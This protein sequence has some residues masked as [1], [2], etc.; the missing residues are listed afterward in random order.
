LNLCSAIEDHWR[1]TAIKIALLALLRQILGGAG[2]P[3]QFFC[4]SWVV[5]FWRGRPWLT[6]RWIGRRAW[7]L[8]QAVSGSV[9]PQ[10]AATDVS[11]LRVGSDRSRRSQER[12][13]DGETACAR[14]LRSIV[15]LHRCRG[16]G[17]PRLETELLVQPN[18]RLAV[19]Q[20]MAR[21]AG[22]YVRNGSAACRAVLSLPAGFDYADVA[23]LDW[24]AADGRRMVAAFCRCR[25]GGRAR[26]IRL[27][28]TRMRRDRC[29]QDRDNGT[30]LPIVRP[31]FVDQSSAA[32]QSNISLELG[33][34]M[35]PSAPSIRQLIK[36]HLLPV[37]EFIVVGRLTQLLVFP[38]LHK[39][40]PLQDSAPALRR[41]R[42]QSELQRK[43]D[44]YLWRV[45]AFDERV[46]RM[47]EGNSS[48]P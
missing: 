38:A 20:K 24:I 48:P 18:N 36:Q 14:R 37:A 15:P 13:T 33:V 21:K 1:S 23:V 16:L 30:R 44:S 35:A 6:G 7:A 19:F 22:G 34:L 10:G 28:A 8:A 40:A 25:L 12:S 41:D 29:T 42:T 9:R 32:L 31:T 47:I 26:P 45:C 43:P 3:N 4:D 5:G 11:A 2:F 17:C 27:T 39:Y 46:E